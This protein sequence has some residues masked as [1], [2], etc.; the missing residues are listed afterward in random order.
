[1]KR[2]F[3][4]ASSRGPVT[5]DPCSE[6]MLRCSGS[7]HHFAA[8]HP[9]RVKVLLGPRQKLS[10]GPCVSLPCVQVPDPGREKLEELGG[11]IFARIG[12]DR[13]DGV[14]VTEGQCVHSGV[15]E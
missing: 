9:P 15:K 5:P 12:Q 13:R 2:D 10:A 11:G 7:S 6:I 14:G 8:P 1:M 4:I 3:Y